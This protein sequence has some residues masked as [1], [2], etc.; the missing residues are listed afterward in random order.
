MIDKIVYICRGGII[1]IQNRGN[2]MLP[3]HSRLGKQTVMRTSGG[4][5]KVGLGFMTA[6]NT[7][8]SSLDGGIM[9]IGERV[10]VNRNCIFVC[11]RRISI[12]NY[13]GFGPNVCIYDHDHKFDFHGK[14]AGYDYEDVVIGDNCWIGAGV[15]ILKGTNIGEGSIIGAGCIIKGVIPP[16]SI[17]TM[18]RQL[19]IREIKDV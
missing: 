9:I 5:I 14:K 4:K 19:S 2:V 8:F 6:P 11:R 13:C 18:N 17:V 10:I 16:H 3:I 1:R 7:Y 12:G 15:I